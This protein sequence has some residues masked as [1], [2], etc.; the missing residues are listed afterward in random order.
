MFAIAVWDG[1]AQRLWL[2]R[3]R[4]GKKPLYYL[5]EEGRLL[6]GSEIKAILEAPSVSREID[7]TALSDYLSLLYVPSPKTIF[8]SIRKLPPAHY[9]VATADAFDVRPYWD[10]PFRPERGRSERRTIEEL[11]EIL[12]E[13]TRLRM[14]SD[15]PL[16]AFLSGGVDSSAVVAMM[17]GASSVIR[18]RRYLLSSSC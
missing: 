11:L 17:A 6:F 8:R 10:L 9:A 15:V 2:A 13:A 5:E 16:G 18:K 7:L 12:D 3:D 14:I 4:V 1:P